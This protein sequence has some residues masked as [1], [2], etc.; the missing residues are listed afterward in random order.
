MRFANKVRAPRTDIVIN[1]SQEGGMVLEEFG[2]G[3]VHAGRDVGEG[4]SLGSVSERMQL[5]PLASAPGTYPGCLTARLPPHR[6]PLSS[7]PDGIL[8]NSAPESAP[9]AT[10]QRG[11]SQNREQS[12]GL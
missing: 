8:C 4:G 12:L 3:V 11:S 10:N 1:Q 5:L 7:Q 9:G 6:K 2:Q